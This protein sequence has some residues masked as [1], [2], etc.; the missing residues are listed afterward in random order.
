[1]L[2]QASPLIAVFKSHLDAHHIILLETNQ[3]HFGW[4]I[5]MVSMSIV[6]RTFHHRQLGLQL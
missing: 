1:M 2:L 3:L 5:V 4:A 6:L